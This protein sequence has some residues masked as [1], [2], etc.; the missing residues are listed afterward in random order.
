MDKN[1][2]IRKINKKKKTP[3][4]TVTTKRIC[5][6][7]VVMFIIL[8][9]LIGRIGFLQFV[10]GS[11]LKEQAFKQQ[12][13]SRLINPKRG[14]ILDST[15]KSLAISAKVDTVSINPSR[16]KDKTSE[17]TKIK[18]EKVAKALSE[19]FELDYEETLAKFPP[20]LILMK[21]PKDITHIII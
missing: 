4:N 12:T 9:L 20:A 15:G 5:N 16:I 13:V 10:Q 14:N 7:M 6:A 1:S 2:K 3:T 18:K 19:I 8:F 17:L 11:S 21:I